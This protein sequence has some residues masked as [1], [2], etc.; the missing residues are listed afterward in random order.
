MDLHFKPFHN[1]KFHSHHE[2]MSKLATVSNIYSPPSFLPQWTRMV[3]LCHA[4]L[5][6][7][8]LTVAPVSLFCQNRISYLCNIFA[9]FFLKPHREHYCVNI[10]PVW[11]CLPIATYYPESG[12]WWAL[13]CG[14]N[15]R[16]SYRLHSGVSRDYGPSTEGTMES[17]SFLLVLWVLRPASK[18]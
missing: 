4:P 8:P 3:G 1:P 13:G 2:T 16:G 6:L 5:R 9:D 14:W 11:M 12:H 7:A 17:C 15:N 18:S 10:F